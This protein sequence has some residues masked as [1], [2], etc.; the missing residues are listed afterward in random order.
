MRAPEKKQPKK[1]GLPPPPLIIEAAGQKY[2]QTAQFRYLGGLVN[3]EGE[4]TQEI[5][6]RSRAA[7]ACI[8]RFSR[9]L[10]D[11]PGAQWRL[12]FRLLR[13]EAME[14]LLYRCMT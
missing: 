1:G 13:V 11:W 6:H 4:L 3:K 5:N 10:I 12:K 8:S 2:A 14:A 7:W 9:E